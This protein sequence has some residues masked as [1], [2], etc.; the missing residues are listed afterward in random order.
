METIA[1]PDRSPD[2]VAPYGSAFWY[3]EMLYMNA[4]DSRIIRMQLNEDT[5]KFHV[6]KSD[7]TRGKQFI[8]DVKTRYDQWLFD[9]FES[10][11]F[12]SQDDPA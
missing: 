6:V 9:T 2:Y 7:G 8:D 12:G 11:F 1:A 3:A 10:K 4:L 5:G